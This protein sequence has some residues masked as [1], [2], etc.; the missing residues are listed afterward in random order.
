MQGE[1][2]SADRSSRAG[3]IPPSAA[4]LR[5][6]FAAALSLLCPGWGHV[7]AG[8]TARGVLGLAA[9]A[10]IALPACAVAGASLGGAAAGTVG[11]CGA[12][13]M[14]GAI[15]LDAA[16]RAF[17]QRP[18]N[19][20]AAVA[21]VTCF[22]FA[23]FG[24]LGSELSWIGERFVSVYKT[25]TTS[26]LPTLLPGDVFLVDVRERGHPEPG[27]VVIFRPP[28]AGRP[29][30]AKRVVAAAGSVVSLE[31]G[32]LVVD[33]V[34]HEVAGAG[35]TEGRHLEALGDAR[36]R[37]RVDRGRAPRDFGPV[38]VPDGHVFVLGDNR[39]ES[40]D[41]RHFGPIAL[42]E[43]QGR[44]LRVLWSRAPGR[45]T[46]RWRRLGLRLGSLAP[47]R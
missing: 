13:L 8:H 30:Y 7:Y 44:A 27:E 35:A 47:L 46:P 29:S 34:P 3:G 11:L 2:S 14:G 22:L 38:Q 21:V 1:L 40:V 17:S 32:R 19:D 45:E 36:Y 6:A 42:D 15:P 9:V 23:G 41:S 24:V 28:E 39:G 16:R 43:I 26:M 4:P 37:V 12:W 18:P 33:G 31:A 5:A 20:V 10:L 25:P